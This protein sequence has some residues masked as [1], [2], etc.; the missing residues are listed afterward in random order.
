MDFLYFFI[1]TGKNTEI[2]VFR[3]SVSVQIPKYRNIFGID[4]YRYRIPNTEKN[5]DYP[6]LV[7]TIIS[8]ITRYLLSCKICFAHGTEGEHTECN[9]QCGLA[10][11][12]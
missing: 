4:I 6:A 1:N 2:V 10:C 7:K 8:P 11:L 3:Y 12:S 9:D 5:T